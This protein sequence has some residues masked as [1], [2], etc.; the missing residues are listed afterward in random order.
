MTTGGWILWSRWP[1]ILDGLSRVSSGPQGG[2]TTARPFRLRSLE[3]IFSRRHAKRKWSDRSCQRA[4][5]SGLADEGSA[6]TPA[7]D[8]HGVLGGSAVLLVLCG[9]R[10][11]DCFVP[12]SD[13]APSKWR[14]VPAVHLSRSRRIRYLVRGTRTLKICR[15]SPSPTF[16]S[17]IYR[18]LILVLFCTGLRLGEAVRLRLEDVDLRRAYLLHQGQQGA[19]PDGFR[20]M[21][22]LAR[23]LR[24][25]LRIRSSIAT[26]ERARSL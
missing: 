7:H 24:D 9:G 3:S 4:P 1:P 26:T 17:I 6:G 25:Y 22:R 13:L 11:P 15:S 16:L 14:E 19:F 23:H 21:P 5:R 8:P 10:D 18:T 20:S 2:D 12:G